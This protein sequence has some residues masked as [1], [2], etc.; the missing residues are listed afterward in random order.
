LLGQ[1]EVEGVSFR[2]GH[3]APDLK[4]KPTAFLPCLS[5]RN[6]EE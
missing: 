6:D 2:L 3:T 1:I 5:I 4:L